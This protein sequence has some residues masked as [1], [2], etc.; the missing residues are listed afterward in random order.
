MNAQ[1]GNIKGSVTD[2]TTGE[3]LI[4]VNI[5][6]SEG[7]G[8]ISDLNGNFSVKLDYGIYRFKVSYVGYNQIEKTIVLDKSEKVIV[9]Q[10]ENST[11]EEVEIVSDVAKS[12]ET[13]VAFSTIKPAKLEEELAAQDL[14]MILNST[15][16]VYATQL[17]GGDGDARINIRGFSQRNVAV[18]IDGIPVNDMENGWVYWS[19]WSGL[20]LAT[21]SIQVQRGLGA[22]KLALPSV[23]GTMNIITRG[24]DSKKS[25]KVNQEM[26]SDGYSRS[27]LAL[28]SGRLKNG[29]GVTFSGYYKRGNGWADMTWTRDWFFFV[30]VDKAI[31]DH[32][33]S[34]SAIGSPQS[35]G[36]RAYQNSI[37]EFST[38]YAKKVGIADS[39]YIKGK[40]TNLGLRYNQN[41][42]NLN[43]WST[44]GSDT[45]SKQEKV[46]EK[47]NFYFKPQYSIRDFWNVSSKLYI[48]NIAYLS[49]G[50][51]G[52]TGFSR[53]LT[54]LSDG[55]KDIQSSYN[56]NMKNNG[57][58]LEGKGDFIYAS[59]NDHF[60]YGLLSSFGWRFKKNWELSGGL[61]LRSYKGSHYRTTYDL[62]GANSFIDTYTATELNDKT[63][64]STVRKNGDIVYYHNDAL[65][66][67]GGLFAQLNVKEGNWSYF[68]NLTMAYSGYN[69][70]DYFKKKDLV[71]NGQ[72][73]YQAVGYTPKFDLSQGKFIALADTFKLNGQAYTLNSP[74]A[75]TAETG[76]K[77]I[78]GYTAK[79]G[80]NYNISETQNVYINIGYL[81]KAPRFA[82]VYDNNN[83][84]YK[85][86][87]NEIV[88]A[89]ELGY[90]FFNGDITVDLN[91]YLTNWQNKPADVASSIKIDDVT[92][93]VNINGMNAL[94]K[95]LETEIA[96]QINKYILS[97]SVISLGDWRWTS[98]DSAEVVNDNTGEVVRKIFFDAKGLKVGDAAQTQLRESLRWQIKKGLYL[99]STLTFFG[100]NYSNFD[101]MSLD[102]K[103]HPSS[104]D[105]NGNPKQSW[106]IPNYALLDAFAGYS[107]KH[108][109]LGFNIRLSVL[110]VLDNVY[111]T[112]AH[113]NDG[114]SGQSW[115]SFDAKSA[116]VFFGMGRRFVTSLA[117]NF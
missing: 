101:P 55:L 83:R 77:Y 89:I 90:T 43:R 13:P 84:M 32:L 42:G 108:K 8:I 76:W 26:G 61:D 10:L 71:I 97:E 39:N 65:V 49:M 106:K 93:K 7:K 109:K 99:K 25:F 22:S 96:W 79:A 14:P 4:G 51:G 98:A 92:Y 81:N 35:H 15:P 21:R 111:I 87:K 56:S 107:F 5:M 46:N 78:P 31:G 11:L 60:W 114:Y 117:I 41:W 19:N 48:S 104:F 113:N 112:D 36:Q 24:I 74:E 34:L 57:T 70:I 88:K 37:A 1:Q 17:G 30:R 40:P 115:N 95:G 66:R 82:N 44:Q 63:N 94:H 53:T 27:S 110:N 68:V 16:G 103:L 3:K 9:F 85:Q 33:L 58:A 28:N 67:W 50:N 52:G 72:T 73:F 69:R 116:A 47:I 23:G 2:K 20:D 64:P 59:N 75:R 102:P 6:Y 54:T 29:W 86:I 105:A 62:L 80:A 38:D 100:D 45:L 91:A 12:R 18:M